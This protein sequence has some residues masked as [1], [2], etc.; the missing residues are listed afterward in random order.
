MKNLSTPKEEQTLDLT[1]RPKSWQEYVGQEKIKKNLR[2]IIDAAKKRSEPPDHLLFYGCAGM[3]KTTLAYVIANEMQANIK[4]TSGPALEKTG[5]L[6]AILTSLNEGDILFVDECHRLNRLIEEYLYSA[7]EDFKLNI[8]VGKGP[9]ARTMTLDLPHFTLI[10]ATTRMALLSSPIRNRFGGIFQ[11][12]FYEL[13]D[14]KKIIQ[15]SSKILGIKTDPV[16]VE[17]IA[18]CSRFTPRV[19][20]RLLKRARDFAQVEGEDIIDGKT[21][22]KALNFLEIDRLGLEPGDRKI[23]ETIIKKFSGGPVGI[24][25]LAAATSEERDSIMEI[26]EPYLMQMGFI[27]RTPRGRMATKTA[28][29]HLGL[30][31]KKNQELL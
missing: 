13:E 27:E 31:Y 12:N 16:A 28:Y 24:Q 14:I 22:K 23:L 25:T 20:N 5:D 7:M 15:R 21:A 9:M 30:E 29:R 1:L 18:G 3:G 19:A 4:T 6:A 26:Y 10:G 11:L 2:I 8:V 17:V